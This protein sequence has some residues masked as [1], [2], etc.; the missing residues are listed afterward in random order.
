MKLATFDVGTNTVLLLVVESQSNGNLK[1]IL[2]RARITRLGKGV[3]K[4][5]KLDPGAAQ[6]TLETI[7]EFASEARAAGAEKIIAVATSAL[8]DARDGADFIRR[9]KETAGVELQI[10]PGLEEA[11]LSRLAVERSLNL[12]PDLHLLI[13]DIGGGSTELI[14]SEPG[15]E[16]VAVSMQIGSVRLTERIIEHDP[17]S[18]DEIAKLSATID[19]NLEQLRWTFRPEVLV[20]IAGTVTTIAAVAMGMR[21]YDAARVHGHSLTR[22]E[23]SAVLKKFGAVT[24]AERKKIPGLVEARAD[25]IFAGALILDRVMA[26]FGVG[27]VIVSD[28]GVRWGLAWREFER[29]ASSPN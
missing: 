4:S 11:E 15:R 19:E 13:T 7:T 27:R 24:L 3:D 16:L 25:V 1:A 21:K 5:G 28:Q 17:P 23:V 12:D 8:R 2:E 14:R 18:H 20:G 9:V 10:V 29:N 6:T 22:A 26:H